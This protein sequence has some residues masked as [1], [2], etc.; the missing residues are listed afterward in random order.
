MT[1]CERLWAL[2]SDY[3]AHRVDEILEVVYTQDGP[4]IARVSARLWDLRQMKGL[5]LKRWRDPHKKTLYWYQFLRP[6]EAQKEF[7]LSA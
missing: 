3:K 6:S 2:M 1:Q 4:S 7:N 5:K